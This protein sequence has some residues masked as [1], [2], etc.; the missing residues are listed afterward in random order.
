MAGS[1]GKLDSI[2]E[3]VKLEYAQLK[4]QLRMVILTDHIKLDDIACQSM[5]VV[6]IWRKLKETVEGDIA[7]GVL[8][9]SLILLPI[10][11]IEKL[12]KSLSNNKIP[13]NSV[14][15]SR[16]DDDTAYVRVTPKLTTR[17]HIVGMITELFCAGDLQILIGTHCL[18]RAGT[19]P[20]STR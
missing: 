19:R 5:G 15:I 9:G 3:I 7:I 6:P 10:H 20:P 11:S 18:A 16:F 2:V 4:E 17:N 12:Y 13:E 14:R 8:C 1:V